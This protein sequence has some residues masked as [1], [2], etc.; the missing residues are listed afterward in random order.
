ME[1]TP[2]KHEEAK[3]NNAFPG[4]VIVSTEFRIELV[5]VSISQHDFFSKI[6]HFEWSWDLPSYFLI[7]VLTAV[8]L[9]N[10]SL[11]VLPLK[12]VQGQR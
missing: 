5:A 4:K 6:L 2:E 3:N 8:H 7:T 11:V 10:L 12:A 9:M 1:G